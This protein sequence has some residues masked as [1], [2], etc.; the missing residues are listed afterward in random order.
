MLDELQ[1]INILIQVAEMAQKAGA[2]TLD[3]AA[4]THAAVK[5]LTA[6]LEAAAKEQ[7]AARN[8]PMMGPEMSAEM[9]DD[10]VKNLNN[11][12]GQNGK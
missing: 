2:L 9:Q 10:K 7:Q 4:A 8:Q 5:T 6:K 3:D 12:K 1:A 11:K